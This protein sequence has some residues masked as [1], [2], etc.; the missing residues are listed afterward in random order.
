MW[1]SRKASKYGATKT[2][3]NGRKYDS[4]FEAGVAADIEL[5]V[6][7]GDVVKVEP[8]QTF[9]LYG[10]NGNRICTHR[11]DFLLTFKDGHQ[12]DYEAKGFATAIWQIKQKLFEDNCPDIPYLVITPRETYYGHARRNN[13]RSIGR[14]AGK[15]RT[16]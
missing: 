9:N 8:Q 14:I 5:L 6:K 13:Q 1:Y 2:I 11:P 12:E 16:A 4:K 15:R 7:C 10:K 3:F